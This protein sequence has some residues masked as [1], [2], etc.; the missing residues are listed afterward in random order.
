MVCS[1]CR[2]HEAALPAWRLAGPAS[3]TSSHH[4]QQR[5][6]HKVSNIHLFHEP[7][8]HAV[9]CRTSHIIRA[10][11]QGAGRRQA[12]KHALLSPGDGTWQYTAQGA[13]RACMST[14]T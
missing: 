9:L 7:C 2:L 3:N 4:T 5:C 1:T 10:M 6:R 11:S 12:K 8:H 13:M 14:C